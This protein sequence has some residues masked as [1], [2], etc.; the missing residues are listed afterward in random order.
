MCVSISVYLITTRSGAA[1]CRCVD[2][3]SINYTEKQRQQ[4]KGG[5]SK[6]RGGRESRGSFV[7]G[8]ILAVSRPPRVAGN[9]RHTGKPCVDTAP[10]SPGLDRQRPGC[11][12]TGLWVG[13]E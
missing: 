7:Y 11:G 4:E 6:K 1:T 13:L 5:D 2:E 9:D 12:P 8:E 10:S 3:Q